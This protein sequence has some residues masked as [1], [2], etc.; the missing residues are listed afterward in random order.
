MKANKNMPNRTIVLLLLSIAVLALTTPSRSL[1]E[2]RVVSR[3][4]I[5]NNAKSSDQVSNDEDH[6]GSELWSN[7]CGHCHNKRSPEKFSDASWSVIV[8]HM[9][10]RANL[11]GEEERKIREFLE[12][13]N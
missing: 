10:V 1:A 5:G 4:N 8:Q 6:S 7:N 3:Q 12:S 13:A 11:T 9:K 2:T